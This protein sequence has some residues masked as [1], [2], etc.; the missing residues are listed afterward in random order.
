MTSFT[1]FAPPPEAGRWTSD[2]ELGAILVSVDTGVWSAG[3]DGLRRA[4]A[5]SGRANSSKA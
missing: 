1:T 3:Q 2:E 5:T 4:A